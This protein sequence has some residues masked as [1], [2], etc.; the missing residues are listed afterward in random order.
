MA[1]DKHHEQSEDYKSL[2]LT[3][4]GNII[5][6][7]HL[8]WLFHTPLYQILEKK[9]ENNSYSIEVVTDIVTFSYNVHEGAGVTDTELVSYLFN[10]K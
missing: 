7:S 1:L 6:H 4:L 2:T 10:V 3:S 8:S 9:L 5:I